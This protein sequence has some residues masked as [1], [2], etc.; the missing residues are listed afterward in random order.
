M[1]PKQARLAI[2]MLNDPAC[3][4]PCA[5]TGGS[6]TQACLGTYA[7]DIVDAN[8]YGMKLNVNVTIEGLRMMK[9][10][11]AS[12]YLASCLARIDVKTA[13]KYDINSL[14]STITTTFHML[15]PS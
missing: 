8:H 12:N 1:F 10:L 11:T 13:T 3:L 15:T 2:R 6:V 7:L 14:D 9:G 5:H 4:V